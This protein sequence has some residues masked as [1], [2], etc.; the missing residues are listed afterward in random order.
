M[1]EKNKKF[2]PIKIEYEGEEYWFLQGEDGSGPVAYLEQCDK[3]GNLKLEYCISKSFAHVYSS[4]IMRRY[5]KY[6][7]TIDNLL[8]K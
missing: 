4:R 3:E 6:L 5:G 8:N 2:K 1:K 7:C